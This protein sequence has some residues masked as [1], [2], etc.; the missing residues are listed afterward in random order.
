MKKWSVNKKFN[1]VCLGVAL[2]CMAVAY[3][4]EFFK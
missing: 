1:M 2:T 3:A 4:I